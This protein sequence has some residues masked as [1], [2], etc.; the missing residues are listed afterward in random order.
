[1]EE[2]SARLVQ[3]ADWI[4]E[5]Q[6]NAADVFP[7]LDVQ[8]LEQ[9]V[10]QLVEDFGCGARACGDA[11]DHNSPDRRLRRLRLRQSALVH[12]GHL[13]P[14]SHEA[15][16]IHGILGKI[17]PIGSLTLED[18]QT[19]ACNPEMALN[20]VARNGETTQSCACI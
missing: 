8:V 20:G 11:D 10:Q 4:N 16:V 7:C 13:R 1:M 6:E 14:S 5:L 15:S 9:G 2:A 18:R 17:L 12:Y 3:E 19:S